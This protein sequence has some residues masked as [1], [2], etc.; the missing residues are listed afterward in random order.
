MNQTDL[1]VIVIGIAIVFVGLM[2]IILL[3]KIMSALCGIS[4]KVPESSAAQSGPTSAPAGASTFRLPPESAA[5]IS[6]VIAEEL[7]KEASSIRIVS[8]KKL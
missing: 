7:G 1:S 4:A 8:V 6:A 5:V 2:C 3:C